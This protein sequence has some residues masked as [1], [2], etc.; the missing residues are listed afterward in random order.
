MKASLL[1]AMTVYMWCNHAAACSL[2]RLLLSVS[3]CLSL[4]VQMLE[5]CSGSS[6]ERPHATA[7][8]VV[9]MI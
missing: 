3:G 5:H 6:C 7:L 8:A 9:S 4:C 2:S 1:I